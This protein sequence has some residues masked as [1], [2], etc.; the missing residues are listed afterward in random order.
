MVKKINI[1]DLTFTF[2]YILLM[3]MES[4]IIAI[5]KK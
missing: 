5:Y 4:E 1:L 3:R 2:N